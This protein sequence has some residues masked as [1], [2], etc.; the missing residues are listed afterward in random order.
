MVL[1][2]KYL[3]KEKFIEKLL[4]TYICCF[5][6]L[7]ILNYLVPNKSLMAIVQKHLVPLYNYCFIELQQGNR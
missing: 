7:S 6:L 4:A 3:I 2:L 5:S 1:A